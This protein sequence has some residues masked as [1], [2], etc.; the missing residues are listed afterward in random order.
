MTFWRLYRFHRRAGL[1]V[2]NAFKRA[3]EH[4][5]DALQWRAPL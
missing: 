3:L 5:L 2:R 4:E 1:T